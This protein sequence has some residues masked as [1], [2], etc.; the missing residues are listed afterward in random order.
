M[1][2]LVPKESVLTIDVHVALL[3][4]E[5][6]RRASCLSCCCDNLMD[7]VQE[8]KGLFSRLTV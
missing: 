7:T 2:F 1:S 8:R 5:H 4:S 3:S 6:R